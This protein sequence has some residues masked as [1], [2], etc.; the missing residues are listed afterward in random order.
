MVHP[1][2][3]S[4]Y[5]RSFDGKKIRLPQNPFFIPDLNNV[6]YHRDNVYGLFLTT[7]RL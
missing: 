4:D 5:L 1:K 2:A 3:T 7:G 6:K